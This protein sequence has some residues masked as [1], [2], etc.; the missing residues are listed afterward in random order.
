MSSF[1]YD[2]TVKTY[3]TNTDVTIKVKVFRKVKGRDITDE[4]TPTLSFLLVDEEGTKIHAAVNGPAYGT[5]EDVPEG[6]W[7]QIAGAV[8]SSANWKD[9]NHIF[10]THMSMLIIPSGSNL[11]S[12][13]V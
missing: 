6:A 13:I 4:T 10:S 11:T 7:I 12:V 2:M 1:F 9:P 3:F 8:V 5:F